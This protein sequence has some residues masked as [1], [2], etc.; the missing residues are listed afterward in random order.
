MTSPGL[1]WT[2]SH[3]KLRLE[4]LDRGY[5]SSTLRFRFENCLASQTKSTVDMV[6]VIYT[7]CWHVCSPHGSASLGLRTWNAM[8]AS[9]AF[10][11]K[12][13]DHMF[14]IFNLEVKPRP[15]A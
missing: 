10:Y 13:Y 9:S 14:S 11:A 4:H 2:I 7:A 12:A 6:I 3:W 15:R 1:A 8:A 5:H